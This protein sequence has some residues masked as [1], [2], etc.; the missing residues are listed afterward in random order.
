VP[1]MTAI[2][3]KNYINKNVTLYVNSSPNG[4]S[5]NRSTITNMVWFTSDPVI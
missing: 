1:V 2:P 4:L 3:Q 5:V